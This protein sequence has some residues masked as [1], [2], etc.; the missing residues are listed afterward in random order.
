MEFPSSRPQPRL[1]WEW[2]TRFTLSSGKSEKM[3]V[4]CFKWNFSF[5]FFPH[6][7]GAKD[8][9][10]ANGKRNVCCNRVRNVFPQSPM[11]SKPQLLKVIQSTPNTTT[12]LTPNMCSLHLWLISKFF[13]TLFDWQNNLRLINNRVWYLIARTLIGN[14]RLKVINFLIFKLII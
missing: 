6:F 2:T 7:R 14:K 10:T 13:T 1:E 3:W 11:A 8:K 5:Y 4:D 9:S 12:Q